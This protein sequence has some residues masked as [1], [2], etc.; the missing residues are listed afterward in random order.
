[1]ILALGVRPDESIRHLPHEHTRRRHKILL[2]TYDITGPLFGV[3]QT[4]PQARELVMW[5]GIGEQG[6]SL[7]FRAKGVVKGRPK[8]L[9]FYM[10]KGMFNCKRLHMPPWQTAGR[11][12]RRVPRGPKVP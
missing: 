12:T 9:L 1:M 7:R 2:G 6:V 11:S 5:R 10:L 4:R 8:K 3:S